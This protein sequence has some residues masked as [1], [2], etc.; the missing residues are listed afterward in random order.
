MQ[1]VGK[2]PLTREER[3]QRENGAPNENL[4]VRINRVVAVQVVSPHFSTATP[5]SMTLNELRGATRSQTTA[6]RLLLPT[7]RPSRYPSCNDV[8]SVQTVW[9]AR[10]RVVRRSLAEGPCRRCSGVVHTKVLRASRARLHTTFPN[11]LVPQGYSQQPATLHVSRPVYTAIPVCT[12]HCRPRG[13]GG[14]HRHGRATTCLGQ[15][16]R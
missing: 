13:N 9:E 6:E 1:R 16:R 8:M 15:G 11:G 7:Q 14:R 10:V 2:P 3:S 12:I 4:R 5:Q